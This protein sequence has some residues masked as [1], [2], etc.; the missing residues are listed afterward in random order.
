M[1]TTDKCNCCVHDQVCGFKE[2]YQ[3]ACASINMSAYQTRKGTFALMKDSNINVNIHCPHIMTR[4]V[5][6]GAEP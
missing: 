6:R 3:A 4:T 2:E 5:K 1:I